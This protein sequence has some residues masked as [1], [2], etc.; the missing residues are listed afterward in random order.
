MESMIKILEFYKFNE[1]VIAARCGVDRRTVNNWKRTGNMPV[2]FL[3]KLGFEAK[4]MRK[5]AK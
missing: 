5:N 4:R 2:K 3:E 1:N